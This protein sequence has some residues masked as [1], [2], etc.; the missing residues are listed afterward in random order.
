MPG[1][2]CCYGKCKSDSRS[3]SS[4]TL[5]S[6]SEAVITTGRHK[7]MGK[8]LWSA[9][10]SAEPGQNHKTSL[11]MVKGKISAFPCSKLLL[12]YLSRIGIDF[13][14]PLLALPASLGFIRTTF[15]TLSCLIFVPLGFSHSCCS[16]VQ[17]MSA[18]TS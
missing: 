13:T 11:C 14:G 15:S 8:S 2:H 3:I 9:T 10:R 12:N 16:C 18:G 7:R 6:I 1:K 17:E 5:F 4:C